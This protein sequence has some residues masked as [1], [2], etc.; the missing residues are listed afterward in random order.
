VSDKLTTTIIDLLRHGD[1]QGGRKYRGQLDDPLSDLGWKQLRKTTSNK[2]NWQHI[3]TSP[4]KRCAEFA[5][6]LAHTHSL[7]L[8][9]ESNFKEVS[10][11]LWEGKTAD[12]LLNTEPAK[13]KSYWSDPIN[14][15]PPQGENLLVF[16]ERVLNAWNDLVSDFKGKH[17]LLISHAGVMRMILCNILGM[18][19]TELFKLDIALAKVSRI[20]IEHSDNEQW[21]RL[22]FHGSELL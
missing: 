8:Q 19:L 22:L 7:P 21:P 17:I 15:T 3:V 11:G 13:I 4:L 5:K 20:Q 18:P 6:E 2:Q 16:E 9:T 14:V 1:V 10:F 12:E